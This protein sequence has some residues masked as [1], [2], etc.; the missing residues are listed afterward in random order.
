M[1]ASNNTPGW[2]ANPDRDPFT[3]T[4]SGWYTFQ[5]HF[6]NNGGVLAV[7]M[8]V[9]KLGSSTLSHTWT[10]SDLSDTIGDGGTVGGNRYGYLATNDMPLALDNITRSGI[11][12]APTPTCTPVETSMGKLTAAVVNPTTNYAG[13]LPLSG[14]QIG[15]YFN[16]AGSVKNLTSPVRPTTASSPTTVRRSM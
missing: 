16:K 6:R 4:Q 8:T 7:D 1:S 11:V 14:C 15:V 12:V 2:P 9:S 5:H 3:I 13:P 10:L